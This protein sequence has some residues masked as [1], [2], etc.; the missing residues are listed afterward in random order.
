MVR[1]Y[2]SDNLT[3]LLVNRLH[4]GRRL[5]LRLHKTA[6]PS[7]RLAGTWEKGKWNEAVAVGSESPF[8]EWRE[9]SCHLENGTNESER[10]EWAKRGELSYPRLLLSNV[11]SL[12]GNNCRFSNRMIRWIS[13]T[14]LEK[15]QKQMPPFTEITEYFETFLLFSEI[16]KNLIQS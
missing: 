10:K 6:F 2:L 16:E 9:K 12:L 4:L 14:I 8:L 11:N 7:P 13:G 1:S 3:A 15:I 5:M